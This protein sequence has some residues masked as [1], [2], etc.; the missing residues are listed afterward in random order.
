MNRAESTYWDHVNPKSPRYN[1]RLPKVVHDG[2]RAG[3]F[4]HEIDEYLSSLIEARD[5]QVDGIESNERGLMLTKQ[6]CLKAVQVSASQ[7]VNRPA[8]KER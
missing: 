4:Q 6:R 7:S 8:P 2:M 1:A 3:L 5:T